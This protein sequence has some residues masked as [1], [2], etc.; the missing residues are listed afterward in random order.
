M[1]LHLNMSAECCPFCPQCVNSHMCG[2]S[3]AAMSY[4]GL[5]F[6]RWLTNGSPG[7]GSS[8]SLHVLSAIMKAWQSSILMTPYLKAVITEQYG[9]GVIPA[10]YD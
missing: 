9:I 3:I 7:D 4:T 10:M 5:A 1:K 6:V 8:Y 2:I